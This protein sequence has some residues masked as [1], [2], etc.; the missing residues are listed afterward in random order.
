[1]SEDDK[2]RFIK[3]LDEE[4]AKQNDILKNTKDRKEEEIMTI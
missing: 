2:F 3:E 1:M 4:I